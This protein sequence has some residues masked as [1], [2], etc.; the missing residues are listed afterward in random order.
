MIK[1]IGRERDKPFSKNLNT[2]A[3]NLDTYEPELNAT[4]NVTLDRIKYNARQD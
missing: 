2:P 4:V 1:N 3:S